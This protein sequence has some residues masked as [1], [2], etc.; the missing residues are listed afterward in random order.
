MLQGEMHQMNTFAQPDNVALEELTVLGVQ[1][2]TLHVTLPP[3]SV[4]HIC[5]EG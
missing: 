2:D 4:V 1:G 5:V 3:C